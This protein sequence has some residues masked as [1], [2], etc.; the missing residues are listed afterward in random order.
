MLVEV[1]NRADVLA[2]VHQRLG[3]SIGIIGRGDFG[4]FHTLKEWLAMIIQLSVF[5]PVVITIYTA[6]GAWVFSCDPFSKT[7][8]VVRG[9]LLYGW[10]SVLFICTQFLV[11]QRYDGA[12]F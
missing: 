3:R 11:F 4:G 10:V 8:D 12:L 2:M 6:T 5:I 1:Q 9:G 7:I